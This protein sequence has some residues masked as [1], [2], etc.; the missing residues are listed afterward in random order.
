MY[1]LLLKKN[2]PY[3]S[4][5][6]FFIG[7]DINEQTFAFIRVAQYAGRRTNLD[8]IT[9]ALG[10][11]KRNLYSAISDDDDM[12]VY[13]HT[14]GRSGLKPTIPLSREKVDTP[15]KGRKSKLYLGKDIIIDKLKQS[16]E[17]GTKACFVDCKWFRLPFVSSNNPDGPKN[18]CLK[19]QR[20]D[21]DEIPE[22]YDMDICMTM[23]SCLRTIILKMMMTVIS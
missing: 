2:F 5:V 7:S 3:A 10:L 15:L 22:E 21:S 8:A 1:L 14:R 23:K 20:E 12:S 13:A 4:I 9:L 19:I 16:M 11:E 6:P 18:P 17:Q